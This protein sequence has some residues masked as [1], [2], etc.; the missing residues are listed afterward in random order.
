[1][2]R[3]GHLFAEMRGGKGKKI[4]YCIYHPNIKDEQGKIRAPF[5]GDVY[6]KDNSWHFYLGDTIWEPLHNKLGNWRMTI[7]CDK[8]IIADKTFSLNEPN[9]DITSSIWK[10]AGY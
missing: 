9:D 6:I 4:T 8:K 7:E 1:M 5:S 10:R 3:A 2:K